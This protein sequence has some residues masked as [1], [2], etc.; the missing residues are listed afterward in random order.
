MAKKKKVQKQS[1]KN[2]QA[3][4]VNKRKEIKRKASASRAPQK[5]MSMAKVKKNL[6]LLPGLIFEPEMNALSFDAEALKNA[7]AASELLPERIDFAAAQGEFGTQFREAIV[8]MDV[9][10]AKVGDAD[11][12]MM[13]Q[14]MNYFMDQEES[15]SCMNQLIVSLYLNSVQQQETAGSSLDFA[16]LDEALKAYDETHEAYFETR[17][18]EIEA[19]K[20]SGVVVGESEEVQESASASVFT[21]LLERIEEWAG[22]SDL[23]DDQSERVVDDMTALFED[24]AA[25]KEW[26]ELSDINPRRVQSFVGWFERN[27]NPTDEDLV[28]LKN[29]IST[30]FGGSLAQAEF[31]E[32]T[33]G[34][35]LAT[36]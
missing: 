33:C 1:I 30:F 3:A 8:A 4:K 12:Q 34:T 23:G 19:A 5:Q 6:K 35:I 16:A 17:N 27:M 9:R 36:V 7:E 18:A 26:T 15:P 20:G 24:Y 10:F 11:K 21:G 13:T 25:E 32:Q 14:A 2:R 31:G 28:L 29:S 22:A